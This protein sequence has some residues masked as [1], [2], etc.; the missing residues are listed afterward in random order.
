MRYHLIAFVIAFLVALR[1]SLRCGKIIA[2]IKNICNNAMITAARFNITDIA[3]SE[4]ALGTYRQG[5]Q[6][7]N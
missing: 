1:S 5:F 2:T 3:E 7:I 6:E 4:R